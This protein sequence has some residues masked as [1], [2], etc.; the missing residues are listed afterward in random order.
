MNNYFAK[1]TCNGLICICTRGLR[2]GEGLR[3][4]P[5]DFTNRAVNFSNLAEPA[6]CRGLG[7]VCASSHEALV[8]PCLAS[9]WTACKPNLSDHVACRAGELVI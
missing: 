2:K 9:H 8:Q 6:P 5:G 1:Y 4:R 3:W 7:E